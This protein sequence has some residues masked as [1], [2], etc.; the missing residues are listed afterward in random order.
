MIPATSDPVEALA[1]TTTFGDWQEIV[2]RSLTFSWKGISVLSERHSR[3]A[4]PA[5]SFLAA[6]DS[7]DA[8]GKLRVLGDS[9]LR[10]AIAEALAGNAD[11]LERLPD[12]LAYA[13]NTIPGDLTPIERGAA[14][15]LQLAGEGR[16]IRV[17]TARRLPEDPAGDYFLKLFNEEIR[18]SVSSEPVSLR[19]PDSAMTDA[20][21]NGLALLE[22]VVPE[23]WSS[24]L[25]HV[26]TVGIIDP[27]D[28][29]LR[30]EYG[31][32]DLCQ[33]VSTHRIPAT[34]FLSPTPLR[35]CYHA[36]E[37]LLHEAAH[38]KLSD[39]VL[40]YDIFRTGY[41]T[42]DGQTVEAIWNRSLSWNSASWPTDRA[43]YAAHVY[44]Y[45]AL[46]W[47]SLQAHL[48]EV[49]ASYGDCPIDVGQQRQ[50]AVDKA[51]YLSS[52]LSSGS[53][54][55]LGEVGNQL[56]D[57]LMMLLTSIDPRP[58]RPDPRL[59][60]LLER[61]DRETSEVAHAIATNAIGRSAALHLVQSDLVA[62]YRIMSVLGNATPPTLEHYDGD[63]WAQQL[64]NDLDGYA[65]ARIST[66]L[67]ELLASTLRHSAPDLDT[68]V[69][70]ERRQKTLLHLMI[71]VIEH[72]SRHLVEVAGQ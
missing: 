17:W 15:P 32:S 69:R 20:M 66:A 1:S 35:D 72:P 11:A 8:E 70:T 61:F 56:L 51:R 47:T 13:A 29:V 43:L 21:R 71:D 67:R 33:N 41:D 44:V 4:E 6:F 25:P 48:P 40:T 12:L 3:I 59:W 23:L 9:A 30:N 60:L 24:V 52:Q 42:A 63:A 39:L 57:F 55:D 7:A 64:D 65:L 22:L 5:N 26:S 31:R 50:S 46:F 18:S 27:E 34:I 28:P 53:R 45:L 19:D 10:S 14:L 16:P 58:L 54:G 37:G 68:L 2:N 38:K 62:T 36:A 49:T